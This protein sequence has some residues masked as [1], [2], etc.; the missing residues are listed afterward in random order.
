MV[1]W[2]DMKDDLRIEYLVPNEQ[3]W[4]ILAAHRKSTPDKIAQEFSKRTFL[5]LDPGET[6]GV[7]LWDGDLERFQLFQLETKDIGPAYDT[8]LALILHFKPDMIRAEEY[9]VYNWVNHDWQVLH[10]P[11]LIG[12]IKALAHRTRKPITFKLAQHAKAMWTD[13]NLKRCLLY[14]PGLK[15]ARDACRHACYYMA[16]PEDKDA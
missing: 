13:D 6:T 8:L 12:A 3:F 5:A 10:T 2:V 9:R 4:R 14:S 7:T 16:K 1:G 15:H 11:Q